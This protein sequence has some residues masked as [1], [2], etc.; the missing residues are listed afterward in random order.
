M[1]FLM[2]K[3]PVSY[4]VTQPPSYNALTNAISIVQVATM[5]NLDLNWHCAEVFVGTVVVVASKGRALVPCA[6]TI[7][8]YFG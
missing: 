3:D 8:F 5:L 7:A 4:S 6:F 1:F 2:R